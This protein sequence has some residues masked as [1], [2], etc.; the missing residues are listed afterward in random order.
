MQPDHIFIAA[1]RRREGAPRYISRH[2]AGTRRACVRCFRVAHH[3]YLPGTG[4]DAST[5]SPSASDCD[6]FPTAK[7]LVTSATH[8]QGII[9]LSSQQ[10]G[11]TPLHLA[12]ANG[13]LPS[14]RLLLAAADGGGG[15][16]EIDDE[17]R[18]PLHFAAHR[19][20]PR[21]VE[22][23]LRAGAN[24]KA[25][26]ARL[27]NG[28]HSPGVEFGLGLSPLVAP[29]SALNSARPPRLMLV[30]QQGDG[31]TALVLAATRGHLQC[32]ETLLAAGADADFHGSVRAFAAE[33]DAGR[34]RWR[35]RVTVSLRLVSLQLRAP[36]RLLQ[37]PAACASGSSLH[38]RIHPT[39]PLRH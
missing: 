1:L 18:T 12:A 5:F 35:G 16:N 4:C 21:C 31:D 6:S 36:M 19:G 20:H 34:A 9:P 37:A 27:L 11:R 17:G 24:I 2:G 15:V 8:D 14:L 25:V 13:K 23:L 28:H 29:A 22:A 38:L 33:A 32:V 10:K 39:R 7:C 26:Q 3:Q 30:P